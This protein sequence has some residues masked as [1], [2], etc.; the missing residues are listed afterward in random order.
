MA[1][2]PRLDLRQSQ[3]LVMT[4]QLRQAI[5]LLQF[6]N[7]EV[8]AFVEEELEKNPLLERDERP[9]IPDA[10][11]T[12]P[13]VVTAPRD[14][15]E[16]VRAESLPEAGNAPLFG[17]LNAYD[18]VISL[19]TQGANI[20]ALNASYGEVGTGG[21]IFDAAEESAVSDLTS[22]GILFVAAAGNESLIVNASF[23]YLS[24]LEACSRLFDRDD[25]PTAVFAANDSMA[26]AVVN[27]LHRRHL[28][29][30]EDISV[31]GANDDH[32]ASAERPHQRPLLGR[33]RSP[34]RVQTLE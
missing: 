29:V 4:P 33:V 13:E 34:I 17:I 1:M 14:A 12:L 19:K 9:E 18:Y 24:A 25:L 11:R 6:S 27:A 31:V 21:G 23:D 5:K 26:I 3:T 10:E 15:A 2:G 30:P 28:S 32:F 16:G 20:V 8:S 7:M 22:T